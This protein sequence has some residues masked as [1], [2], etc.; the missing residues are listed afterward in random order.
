VSPVMLAYAEHKATSRGISNIEFHH[1]GFLTFDQQPEQFDIIFTQLALHHLPD[2]WKS[3]ALKNI[4]N[5]L[6]KGGKLFIKDVVYPSA[7]DDYTPFFEAIIKGIESSAGAEYTK[8]IIAHVKKE[9]ST[10]DWIL[11]EL[12]T[13]SGFS[14]LN[15]SIDNGFIYTY[16]CEKQAT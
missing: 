2:F 9:Y 12:L 3:I 14:I 11:E 16:L 5:L 10:L 1:A 7:I 4:H 6:K 8:E 15:T 13:K